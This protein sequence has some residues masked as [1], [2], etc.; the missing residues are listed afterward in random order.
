MESFKEVSE[1]GMKDGSSDGLLLRDEEGE[2]RDLRPGS[3]DSSNISL[4]EWGGDSESEMTT[5]MVRVRE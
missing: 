4:W 1:A 3:G 5:E 2:P